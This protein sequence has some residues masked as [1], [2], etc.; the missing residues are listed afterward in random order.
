MAAAAIAK[1][2][3]AQ[4]GVRILG[5]VKQVGAVIAEIA[6]PAAVTLEQVE[7]NVGALP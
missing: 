3:L 4:V 5:Y 1:K 7:A 2:L 6:D